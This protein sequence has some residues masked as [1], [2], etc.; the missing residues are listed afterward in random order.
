MMDRKTLDAILARYAASTPGQW[1]AD[2][3]GGY[4]RLS[5]GPWV[6]DGRTEM[7]KTFIAAAHQDVPALVAEVL[8]LRRRWASEHA[9]SC[10][11]VSAE[12]DTCLGCTEASSI[13]AEKE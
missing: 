3:D 11:V 2:P 1:T 5:T 8:R 13:L 4:V 7:N 10:S 12:G 6:A 9:E